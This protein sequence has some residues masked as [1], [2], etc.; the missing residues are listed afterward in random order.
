MLIDATHPYSVKI[1]KSAYSACQKL[2]IS[3]IML[4]RPEWDSKK[5]NNIIEADNLKEASKIIKS[6]YKRVFITTG[7][8]GLEVFDQNEATWFLIRLLDVKNTRISIKNYTLIHGTPPFNHA[9][10]SATLKTFN[11]DCL[12]TKNSGGSLTKAKITAAQE[13]QI[14]III[15]KRP[16]QPCG[17]AF[18]SIEKCI[19]ALKNQII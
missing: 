2:K 6:S 9:S 3:R 8:S 18:D 12:V 10:E 1:S 17:P 16:L 11:I 19:K 4:L 13:L 15:L 5:M 7:I 14:P